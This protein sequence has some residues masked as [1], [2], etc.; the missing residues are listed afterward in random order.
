M[1]TDASEP[2]L[3]RLA[4]EVVAAYVSRTP[5]PAAELS[6]VIQLVFT[7]L[8]NVEPTAPPAEVQLKPAVPVKKSV[9]PDHIVCLEDG[10]KLKMLK[11]HLRTKHGM[12]PGAYRQRWGLPDSYPMVAPNYAAHRSSLA[13]K[14]GLGSRPA[15]PAAT[16]VV[17]QQIPEGVKGRRPARKAL[18]SA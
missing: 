5:V 3:L 1:S 13:K 16:E 8:D 7:A 6:G 18:D 10:M 11:R 4:T 17:V 9:F 14:I 15:N 12:T 2:R